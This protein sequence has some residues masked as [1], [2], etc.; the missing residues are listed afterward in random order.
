MFSKHKE[1]ES[2]PAPKPSAARVATGPTL[3]MVNQAVTVRTLVLAAI[4]VLTIVATIMVMAQIASIIVLLLVAIVFA[5]GI[6][7]SVERAERLHLPR[8]AA[9]LA[10]Y[11][12]LL[13]VLGLLITL[14]VSP[15][16]GEVNTLTH[17]L[18]GYQQQV[19]DAV[20]SIQ[21][22]L[23]ISPNQNLTSQIVG[24]LNTAK[25][26][27]LAV[28]GYVANILVSMLLVLILS[29][30][31]LV[32]SDRLKAFVVDLFPPSQQPLAADVIREMGFRM[33]G[34][35]RATT[36]NMAVVGVASGVAA[37]FLHLPS[38]VLLGI[39]AGL[40]SA[41]PLV[42]PLVG[43]VPAVLLGFT[44]SPS[45]PIVVIIVFAVVQLLDANIVVPPLMNRVVAL[46]A[47]SVVLAL[48]IGG[49]MAGIVGALLAI[50]LA[51]ALHVLIIRVLVPAIH[52]SQGRADEAF[53]KAAMPMTP[54]LRSTAPTG[55]G[56][57]KSAR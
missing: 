31:W 8:P 18:P 38:P 51:A 6:R 34:Y 37:G 17:Q 50:P 32:T 36:I 54:G 41:I 16:V 12:G 4:L 11:V 3:A 42:G 39:F 55:G 46:P 2:E 19:S 1:P 7:S 25:D 53:A 45:Y 48:L 56:R 10:V 52:H 35:M 15:I 23:N 26:I 30:L 43:A 20:T 47:L 29:F 28:S 13:L 57:R 24:S 49:A 14:L 44:V 40:T 33:G 5:E 22:Q 9:V 27:L 21:R